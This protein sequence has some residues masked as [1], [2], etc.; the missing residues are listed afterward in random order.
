M[1]VIED[2]FMVKFKNILNT[3]LNAAIKT[4][5]EGF[6][7]TI[8]LSIPNVYGEDKID[9]VYSKYLSK[10]YV[11]SQEFHGKIHGTSLWFIDNNIIEFFQKA[12]YIEDV[13][14]EYQFVRD[15]IC[16]IHNILTCS[17]IGEVFRVL[18][19]EADFDVVNIYNPKEFLEQ[20]EHKLLLVETSLKIE[21]S[22]TNLE[23]MIL[24][25]DEV[26]E[27]LKRI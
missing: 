16:E 24:I 23:Q 12:L 25:S 3:S 8:D 13:S 21:G 1:N 7:I 17:Y 26:Y 14:D 5:N 6:G 27:N 2:K 15:Y 19:E 9:D 4:I 10:S 11:L 18:N 20:K 22:V